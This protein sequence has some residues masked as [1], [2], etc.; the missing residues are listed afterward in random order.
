MHKPKAEVAPWARDSPV[1]DDI[2][3]DKLKDN[4]N[5]DKDEESVSEK[6]DLANN[7]DKENVITPS[8]NS[9]SYSA[10]SRNWNSSDSDRFSSRNLNVQRNDTFKSSGTNV[11]PRTQS[12]IGSI[13]QNF[14]ESANKTSLPKEGYKES[15]NLSARKNIFEKGNEDTSFNKD[16]QPNNS[17]FNQFN[18]SSSRDSNRFSQQD[19][20]EPIS[21]NKMSNDQEEK[22]GM[23]QV[24]TFFLA[25]V[26][27]LFFF[28]NLLIFL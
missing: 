3:D 24:R 7:E 13:M 25:T 9:T 20:F 19:Q 2:K 17:S 28:S 1:N 14:Q 10:P 23:I 26:S 22:G 4:D 27:L 12:K 5:E 21:S 11:G 16:R 8:V 15:I 18:N 6:N